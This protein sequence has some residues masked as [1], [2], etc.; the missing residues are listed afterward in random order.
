MQ[1][2]LEELVWCSDGID[3]Y[4]RETLELVK[5]L[6]GILTTIK[7]NVTNTLDILKTFERNLMFD[8][9]VR[10]HVARCTHRMYRPRVTADPNQHHMYSF[11]VSLDY[12]IQAT[13]LD[14]IHLPTG[15]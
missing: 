9:K 15:E 8:R 14:T 2:G 1:Q 4:I 3:G 5:E 10:C 11:H 12:S 7:D 13:C 6:D